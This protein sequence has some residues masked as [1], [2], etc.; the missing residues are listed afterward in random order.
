MR[1]SRSQPPL[2][3]PPRRDQGEQAPGICPVRDESDS[4]H[5]GRGGGSSGAQVVRVCEK[6]RRSAYRLAAPVPPESAA[7]PFLGRE[8]VPPCRPLAA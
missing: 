4:P 1:A 8:K 6:A 2:E 7:L 3:I 5:A